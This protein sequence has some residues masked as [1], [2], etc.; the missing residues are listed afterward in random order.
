MRNESGVL[1]YS[2]SVDNLL[3]KLRKY[4]VRVWRRGLDI[5]AHFLK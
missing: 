3:K 5:N 2:V 4:M 1:E